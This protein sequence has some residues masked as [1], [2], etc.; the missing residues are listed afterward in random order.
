MCDY[1]LYV[2]RNRLARDGEEVIAYR[3]STGC[4]G[5]AGVLDVSAQ[6]SPK[7]HLGICWPQLKS[8]FFPRR[9]DG[10]TAVC[11][12]PGAT[13]R[14]DPVESK[15]RM[16]LGLEESEDAVFI[17]VTDDEFSYRDGLRFRNGRQILLQELR[18]GQRVRIRSIGGESGAQ[19]ETEIRK[20][21]A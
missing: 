3:F 8:W 4:T 10:P 13:V 18:T 14:L 12:P 9:H 17:Q 15:L 7:P 1:S 11:V 19:D 16:R 21:H 20:S 2:F 6:P 5:F